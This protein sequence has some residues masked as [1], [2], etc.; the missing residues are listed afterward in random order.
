MDQHLSQRYCYVIV[1]SGYLSW[2]LSIDQT[3]MCNVRLQVPTLARKFDIS[4]WF[5][6]VRMDGRAGG[7]TYGNVITKISRM[8]R[9][10]NFL[11]YGASLAPAS[12]AWSSTII[13]IIITMIMIINYFW[14]GRVA[15]AVGLHAITSCCLF[16]NSQFSSCI[17]GFQCHAI[18]NRSKSKSKPV[19]RWSPESGKW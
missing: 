16:L 4:H 13:D 19:N 15:V 12:R 5:P 8:D 3:W 6:V 18:Q 9:I 2:K 14:W 10:P 17:A 7:R 1:V 11:S